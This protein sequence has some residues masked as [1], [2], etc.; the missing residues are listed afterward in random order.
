MERHYLQLE[1]H[2][3]RSGGQKKRAEAQYTE[4][5][6]LHHEGNGEP[7]EVSEQKRDVIKHM[8]K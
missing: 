2:V 8:I 5:L 4:G 7:P 1:Q 6:W 3:Q